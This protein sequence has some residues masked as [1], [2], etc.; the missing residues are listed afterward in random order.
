MK[1]DPTLH[2]RAKYSLGNSDSRSITGLPH[3]YSCEPIDVRMRWKK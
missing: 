1:L 3:T 2:W